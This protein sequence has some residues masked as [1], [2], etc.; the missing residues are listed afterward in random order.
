MAKEFKRLAS[1]CNK[2]D[3][4]LWSAQRKYISGKLHKT[5]EKTYLMKFF[6]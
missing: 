6:K 1:I 3:Y 5:H 2:G 4:A